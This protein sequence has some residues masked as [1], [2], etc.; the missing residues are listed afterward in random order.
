MALNRWSEGESALTKA[1]NKGGLSNAGQTF[2]S[3][4]LAQFEQKKYSSAKSTFSKAVK[5][6]KTRKAANNWIKYVENELLRLE[7]LKEEVV[8]N[9]DVEA[10]ER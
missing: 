5:Y 3:L 4:G 8:I 2:I 1:I 10:E 7:A 6:P 9:T